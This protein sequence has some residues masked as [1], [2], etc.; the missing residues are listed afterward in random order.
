MEHISGTVQFL[1]VIKKE[2]STYH[3]KTEEDTYIR[4]NASASDEEYEIG[5]EVSAFIYPN[6]SGELFAAPVVPPVG[7]DKYGFAKVSE[8]NRD[9]AYVDIGAP[10]EI[11]VPW[12]DLPKLKSVWP[13]EGDEIYMKLRAESDNQLYGR[14][15]PENEVAERFTP[16]KKEDFAE[17]KNKWLEGRPYRLLKVGTF[18][19]TDD[20]RKVF[21]H[22]SERE[23]E[24]RL[25]ELKKFR[26]IGINDEGEING[27]FLK[28]AYKKMDDDSERILDYLTKNGGSMPL[29]DKSSPED[30]KEAFNMSKG[31]FKRALGRLMKEGRIEQTATETN[32]KEQ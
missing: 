28:Q 14:L 12:I 24:P 9:G 25:G 7:I 26:V 10:R 19:L 3:L 30:I 20:G 4:M 5:E 1:E 18:L 8:V 11:L 6:R 29:N 2:G 32:M 27:S 23:E 22:E 15:I 16:L 31:A 17:L 21:V 13:K